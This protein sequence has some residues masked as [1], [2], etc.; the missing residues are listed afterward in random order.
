MLTCVF[1]NFIKVSV[2]EF[3]INPLYCVS[4]LGYI[5]QCGLKHTEKKLQTLQDKNFILTLENNI[6]GGI[7]SVMGDGY[8]KSDKKRKILY[9]DA[10]NLYGHSMIRPLPYDEIEMW[11]GHPD[12]YMTKLEKI[13]NRPDDSDFG[14]FIEVDLKYLGKIK[15]KTKK[16]PF[17]SGSKAI[18]QNKHNDYIEKYNLIIIQK[19]KDLC[20]ILLIK[21]M[22]NSN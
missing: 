6:R 16:F 12:F 15:Q 13:L 21:K 1:E 19:L 14:Y 22:F 20:L 11:H 5:W 10:T 18:L 3:G 2:H 7:G 17:A 4:S 9:M 8:V